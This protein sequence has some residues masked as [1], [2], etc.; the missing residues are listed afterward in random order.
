SR[1]IRRLVDKGILFTK[2]CE[3]DKRVCLVSLTEAGITL[4]LQLKSEAG[5][6]QHTLADYLPSDS[7]NA[8]RHHLHSVSAAMLQLHSLD[9]ET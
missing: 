6:W 2:S 8:I 5:N 7:R 1:E 4:F 3:Q 9:Q